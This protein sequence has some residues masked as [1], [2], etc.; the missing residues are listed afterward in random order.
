MVEYFIVNY[1]R[2]EHGYIFLTANYF[3]TGSIPFVLTDIRPPVTK[4]AALFML[5]K[6]LCCIVGGELVSALWN[7][8]PADVA[9]F[10]PFIAGAV[11]TAVYAAAVSRVK[12]PVRLMRAAQQT[13]ISSLA[14]CI[15]S[16]LG[17]V[18]GP[19]YHYL[20][21][22]MISVNFIIIAIGAGVTRYFSAPQD[23]R[24]W[25]V[26]PAVTVSVNAL[27]YA[28]VIVSAAG[29]FASAA[30][31]VLGM[32]VLCA[33]IAAYIGVYYLVRRTISEP[34]KAAERLQR[35]AERE[36]FRMSEIR[37][38]QMRNMRHELKNQYAY[39]CVLLESGEYDKLMKYFSELSDKVASTLDYVDC[40]NA[41]INAI[42]A[43]EQGRVQRA[44]ARLVC[45]IAVPPKLNICDV[46][47][48]SLLMNL[49]N[50]AAEYLER[51]PDLPDRNIEAV[52]SMNG[53]TLLVR[54]SNPIAE[55]DGEAAL[56]L[57]TSK[58]DKRWHGCGVRVVRAI[59]E[60]Y[61]GCASY[62][63]V[64]GRFVAAVM[65]NDPPTGG[66]VSDAE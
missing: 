44:D 30:A 13:G 19:D 25:S 55:G 59:A 27:C 29:L 41:T 11:V 7:M 20:Q 60:R 17:G 16:S 58:P 45:K 14:I 1:A 61:G 36:L 47:M 15:T 3:V 54:V 31:M 39:M 51:R 9:I 33:D 37:L 24:L 5:L 40:G 66:G 63:T 8:I 56:R 21:W 12:M 64:D 32:L 4:R 49:I 65:L 35:D 18:L 10:T 62:E 2:L 38:E 48:C 46:D 22:M 43:A 28:V 23:V 6:I 53:N 34:R 52:L 42:I 26:F 50:N 57:E